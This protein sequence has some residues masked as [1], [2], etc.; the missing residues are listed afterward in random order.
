MGIVENIAYTHE[1]PIAFVVWES[2]SGFVENSN[3]A[4]ATALERAIA[5]SVVIAG[6]QKEERSVFDTLMKR[7]GNMVH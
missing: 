5:R 7:F 1:R 6:G 2:E 3:N 4:G